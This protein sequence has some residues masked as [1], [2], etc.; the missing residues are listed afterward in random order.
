MCT[1]HQNLMR[2]IVSEAHGRFQNE[3]RRIGC[4]VRLANATIA[5]Q[6]MSRFASASGENRSVEVYDRLERAVQKSDLWRY[7]IVWL[8]G[9]MYADV[10]LYPVSG[11][12][13][14]LPAN[15]L[16][17]ESCDALNLLPPSLARAFGNA[18][19]TLGATDLVRFPQLRNSVIRL[20]RGHPALLDAIRRIIQREVYS[21]SDEPAR[22]LE[23]TGPGVWTDAAAPYQL[24]RVWRGGSARLF[25]HRRE[26]WWKSR[27]SRLGLSCSI[28]NLSLLC[29]I[30]VVWACLRRKR[31]ASRR[32]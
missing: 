26:G 2:G 21:E 1:V 8:E 9:G 4:E 6:D 18:A 12:I 28:L 11:A 19:W 17:V 25:V 22:T 20:Q 15:V 3:W 29:A 27:D 23:R 14:A 13:L 7:A 24:P 5:R 32:G 31:R 10:D 16:F 30:G